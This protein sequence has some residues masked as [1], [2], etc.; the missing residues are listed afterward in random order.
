[1]DII[2]LEP[3]AERLG[4][5]ITR[6][7]DEDLG[8]PTPCPHYTLGDLIDHV[9]GLALAFAAAAAKDTA[10]YGDQG[11]SG[12]A[13]R[14]GPDWRARI[15]RD[16]AALARAWRDPAA[17]EGM[18]RIAGMDAPARMVGLTVADELAVHGWD[19]ARATGQPYSCEP[20]LLAAAQSFLAQFTSADL[21]AGPDVAF[22]PP[23]PV[24]GDAPPLDRVVAL[25]G[26]D[27]AWSPGD[28]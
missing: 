8:R 15:P 16:L 20:D 25:A 23:R 6:V 1:M 3:G 22:G 26:R 18:T 9:G 28:E 10:T 2:D 13:A 21:P 24:P 27:P 11:P 7:R 14:L 17:W 4:G 19:V 12:D 5:L